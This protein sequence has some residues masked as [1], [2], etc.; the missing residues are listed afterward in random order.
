MLNRNPLWR[1]VHVRT[2]NVIKKIV[3]HILFEKGSKFSKL[4][5]SWNIFLKFMKIKVYDIIETA[6]L[7]LQ[8]NFE[9]LRR[10][11]LFKYLNSEESLHYETRMLSI[12]MIFKA[13]NRMFFLEL[14][15]KC[16]AKFQIC[17]LKF[18]RK[19]IMIAVTDNPLHLKEALVWSFFYV[20]KSFSASKKSFLFKCLY[21]L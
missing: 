20:V 3:I 21:L 1:M 5:N 14:S 13:I 6:T 2:N 7:H 8:S 10:C 11:L 16:T 18:I 15:Q 19:K 17:G 12:S 9:I 4:K